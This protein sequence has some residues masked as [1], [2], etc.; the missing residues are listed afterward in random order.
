MQRAEPRNDDRAGGPSSLTLVITS[1]VRFLRES[2]GEALSPC[3]DLDVIGQCKDL[4]ETERLC[5]ALHPDLVLLDAAAQ[6]GAQFVRRLQA[7]CAGL[8]VVVFAV[9]ESVECV[10]GWAEAGVAGYI[11]C[12]AA[13]TD[14]HAMIGDIAAGRQPCSAPVAGG[15]LRRIGAGMANVAHAAAQPPLTPRELEIVQL[16]SRGL[17]NKDIA[18]RLNIGVATTKSHVHNALAK[19]N[20]QRRGQAASWMHGRPHQG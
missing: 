9:S 20:L 18:R 11:P 12:T 19:L 15:L 1:E 8:R 4:A 2:L 5:L 10:L 13:I 7:G 3:A 16:I 17:S 6:D 14:L